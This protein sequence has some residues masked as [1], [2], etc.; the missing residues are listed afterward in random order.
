MAS[1]SYYTPPLDG[2]LP[3]IWGA[4]DWRAEHTPDDPWIVFPH[5]EYSEEKMVLT[6]ADCA[7]ASH[8]AAYGL[9]TARVDTQDGAVAAIFLNTDTVH[10]ALL[11]TGIMRAGL[12]PL[13]IAPATSPEDVCTL[14]RNANCH[15]IL[16]RSTA[17]MYF[18]VSTV[19]ALCSKRRYHL[20]VDEVPWLDFILPQLKNKDAATGLKEGPYPTNGKRHAPEDV[21]MYFQPPITERRQDP[22]TLT[23]KGIADWQRHLAERGERLK[24]TLWGA[25][26]IPTCHPSGIVMQIFTPLATGMPIAVFSPKAPGKPTIPTPRNT[27]DLAR[28]LECTALVTTSDFLE[29]W[30]QDLEAIHTLSLMR[31]VC[32]T[33]PGLSP[34]TE[35]S[36]ASAGIT[37]SSFGL[38]PAIETGV[39]SI[40]WQ[41]GEDTPSQSVL[42]E[43]PLIYALRRHDSSVGL[44]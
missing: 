39:G 26:S 24:G 31:I 16:T 10:Y 28:A 43:N 36:L 44:Q 17:C 21:A 1:S 19:R 37:M 7:T 18:R 35:S 14:L 42:T 8:R 30:A 29:E 9:H 2:S 40:C 23:H 3:A 38:D 41:T 27:M 5:R 20:R 11:L 4:L 15:R 33:G 25:M 32:Y 12:I 6:F 34:Y 22:V 13:P